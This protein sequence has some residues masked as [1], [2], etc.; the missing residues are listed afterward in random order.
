[1]TAPPPSLRTIL[2]RD[3][4]GSA[5]ARVGIG[6]WAFVLLFE[7]IGRLGGEQAAKIHAYGAVNLLWVALIASAVALPL[8]VWRVRVIHR[9]LLHGR[10]VHGTIVAVE[11]Q[12]TMLALW[13]EY[14]FDGDVRR[15]R[16]AVRHGGP[17]EPI[18]GQRVELALSPDNPDVAFVRELYAP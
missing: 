12:P 6:V 13:V 2:W 7:L 18:I 8:L 4:L 15:R 9:A 14:T 10:T 11:S 16:N 3:F 17:L 5:L 1:M